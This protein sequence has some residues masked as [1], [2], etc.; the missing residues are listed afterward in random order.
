VLGALLATSPARAATVLPSVPPPPDLTR[1]VPFAEAPLERPAI[2]VADLALPE[3]STELPPF[4]PAAVVVPWGGKPTATL[5]QP[6]PLACVGAFFGVAEKAL[7]CGRARI[8]KG[9]YEDAAKALEQAARSGGETDLVLEARYWLGETYWQ[10]GRV[11]PSDRLFRQVVQTAPKTSDFGRWA[12]HASAW[13]ALR[14][15]DATRARDIFAQLLAGAVPAAMEPWARHGLAVASYA[16]GRHDEAVAAWGAL[17]SK[18]V[19]GPLA[20]DVGFWLGESLGRVGEYDRATQELE[21]FVKGGPHALLDAG[22]FRLGWWSLAARRTKQSVDAFRTFLTPSSPAASPRTGTER[23]WAEAGLALALLPTDYPAAREA[24]RGLETRRSLLRDPILLR[25]ARALVEAKRGAEGQAIIQELLGAN[26]APA[27]RAWVLLLNGEASRVQGNLDDA[28]TQYDLAHRAEPSS[29]TGWFAALRQAQ[30]NFQLREF[31]QAARDL[32]G[33]VATAPSAEA[34]ATVLLLQGEAAYHAGNY[35]VAGAAFRRAVIEFPNHPKAA[36][37]RLGVA[38]TA[39]RQN[40][41]DEARRA[42]LEFVRVHPQDPHAPDALLLA[43][44]LALQVPT[45]LNEAKELLDRI[46]TQYPGRPRTEFAKLNRALVRLR[47]ADVKAAQSELR[48]WIGRAPFQPLLGRAHAALG[49]ALLAAGL[50][51]DAGKAFAQAQREGLGALATLGLAAVQLAQAKRDVAKGLFEEARD[52]GTPAVARTAEYGLAAIA[53]Q[54]GARQAFKQPAL[55]ELD[56]APKGPGAPRLLYVLTGLAVEEKDWT[57]ALDRARRL[58][59]EF[60]TDEA[61]DDALESVGASAAAA[62]VWPVAYAA[63]GE[64]R[65]RYPRSPFAEAAFLT[66]AEAQV[67]TGRADVA[68]R[69][70]EKAVASAP[71]DAKLT[72]VWLALARARGAVGDRAAALEAYT[73]AAKDGHGPEWDKTAIFTHAR[74]LAEDKRWKEARAI[75]TAFLRHAAGAD[76]ADAAYALGEAYQGEGDFPAATEYFM[77][78]AYVDPQSTSG[79][80][81]L[82]GAAASLVALKQPDAAAIVY[83]KL[84]DQ[85]QV[86]AEL[87]DAARKGLKE[88]GQ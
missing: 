7:E 69:D 76:A 13:T 21:R 58:A 62:A 48:D 20:R 41:D 68:R 71:A 50:P 28:R 53:F 27:V 39:L 52:K 78:A 12:T 43:S 51:T 83:K 3:G 85:P 82:L 46:I 60:P 36:A 63:Y 22:W 57:G 31:A 44:E 45:E 77:T 86:S 34:R 70:L 19:P 26:L 40:R 42:F 23:D 2:G 29:A 11:E 17:R 64:L 4:P 84:L 67:Q 65:Q 73:R 49:A 75:L 56:A 79:R 87:A 88:I 10:L 37:A 66:L 18:S 38:W 24:A 14:L 30:V 61:A 72:R 15:G 35:A 81:A 8:A 33:L 54:D 16:L 55:A 5:A 74:L 59:D 1:L 6:G 25:F 9:E 47:S 32:G 80:R